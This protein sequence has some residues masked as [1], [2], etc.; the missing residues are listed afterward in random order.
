MSSN[1]TPLSD[2]LIGVAEGQH[3]RQ[4]QP[5]PNAHQSPGYF[6]HVSEVIVIIFKT[7]FENDQNILTSSS[8]MGFLPIKLMIIQI[9]DHN[10]FN[11]FT[12]LIFFSTFV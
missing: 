9:N 11:I 10:Y 6:D 5:D 1:H 4:G 8:S 7:Y 3:T 2:A 12:F